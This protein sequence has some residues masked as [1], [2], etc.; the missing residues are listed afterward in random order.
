MKQKKQKLAKK[1][2]WGLTKQPPKAYNK[3][4]KGKEIKTMAR[5]QYKKETFEDKFARNYYCTHARLNSIRRDK[6]EQHKSFRRN[7]KKTLDKYL[8]E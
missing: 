4:T 1:I 7:F 2:K 5:N 8:N 3:G 6:K